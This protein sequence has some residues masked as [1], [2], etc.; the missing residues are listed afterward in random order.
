M[1]LVVLLALCLLLALTLRGAWDGEGAALGGGGLV[2]RRL[3]ASQNIHICLCSDDSDLRGVAVTIGSVVQS[4]AEPDLLRF[5]FITSPGLKQVATQ[6]LTEHLPGVQLK[7]HSGAQ[8]LSRL[9]DLGMASSTGQ[10]GPFALVP[11]YLDGFL[12]KSF[13]AKRVVYIETGVVVM[14]DV[15]ELLALDLQDSACAAVQSCS[16]R[17]SDLINLEEIKKQGTLNLNPNACG[18][19]RSII[20]IDLPR[21]SAQQVTTKMEEWI[22]RDASSQVGLWTG[23]MGL[24]PWWLAVGENYAHIGEQWSCS[25][26]ASEGMSTEDSK[27][28]RRS[29]FDKKAL[30]KLNVQTDDFGNISPYLATCSAHAK[31]LEFRGPMLPWR[32]ERFDKPAPICQLPSAIHSSSAPA[33]ARALAASGIRVRVWCEATTFVNCSALWASFVS[34]EA[35][36]ALKDF[37]REW[38]DAEDRWTSLKAEHE[39]KI[40]LAHQDKVHDAEEQQFRDHMAAVKAMEADHEED[41]SEKKLRKRTG[42]SK[43]K[44]AKRAEKK[45]KEVEAQLQREEQLRIDR[46]RRA[47][48]GIGDAGVS[49]AADEMESQAEAEALEPSAEE[50]AAPAEN[51]PSA[52]AVGGGDSGEV[53]EMDFG[54]LLGATGA[55]V[56]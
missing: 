40:E 55:G 49:S 54:D 8:Q 56:A 27:Q 23:G 53:M 22:G 25:G 4:A 32:L 16:S 31:L 28:V 34:E 36:C 2:V 41:K 50:A 47:R 29:G 15:G 14:G 1:S 52:D 3:K 18:A 46:E 38:R 11:F 13:R 45:S 21:W 30:R 35:A 17:W 10:S 7:V 33:S 19:S 20:V 44:L 51:A 39:W 6:L 26:L 48:L 9:H 5:H 12:G 42:A 24:V 43:E 37:D